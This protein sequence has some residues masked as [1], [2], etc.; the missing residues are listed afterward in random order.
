MTYEDKAP[1]RSD[2]PQCR[3]IQMILYRRYRQTILT[4]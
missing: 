3:Y 2:D 4:L 1:L